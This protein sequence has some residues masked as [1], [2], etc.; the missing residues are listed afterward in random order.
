M[1]HWEKIHP[2]RFRAIPA[3][4]REAFF[5]ELG[6]RAESEIEELQDALAG[7]DPAGEGYLEKVGRLNVARMQAEE[8]VLA[9][10]ILIAGPEDPEEEDFAENRRRRGTSSWCA[11]C[12]ACTSRRS[13]RPPRRRSRRPVAG[14]S[15]RAAREPG[16]RRTWPR[17]GWCAS[18]SVS[19]ASRRRGRA[20]DAG[21]VVGVGCGAAVFDEDRDGVGGRPPGVARAGRRGRVRGGAA[22]DDQR[23][24]HRSGDRRGRS[25]MRCGEL[26]FD[27]GRVLEPGCGAGMFLGL[28]PASAEL[29]GVELDPATAWIARALYPQANDS[30]R[31]VRC[32]RAC[33]TATSI[34]R[35]G[36][37]RS[38]TCGCTTRGTT[39][40]DTRSAQPLHPQVAGADPARR[41]GRRAD[42]AV[43][44][45]LRQPGGAAGDERTGGARRRGPAADRRAPP[46]GRAPTR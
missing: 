11:T 28:A 7:P 13:S 21:G 16:S 32:T 42:L 19:I 29:A 33:R 35:S 27:G 20:A 39:R 22:H 41:A 24:L 23:A 4:E 2:D 31:V 25:G 14:S 15:R 34:W 40:P 30:R 18:S 36:T 8:K 45:G 10:L 12:S 5:A 6:E 43:H 1:S 17:C 38:P 46:C 26:G 3:S 44:A 9:E 37:F